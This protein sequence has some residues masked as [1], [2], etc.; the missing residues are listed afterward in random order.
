MEKEALGLDPW[1][2]GYSSPLRPASLLS[3]FSLATA[4]TLSPSPPTPGK[5][6]DPMVGRLTGPLAKTAK[7]A[8]TARAVGHQA[9]SASLWRRAFC[10]V[11]LTPTMFSDSHSCPLSQ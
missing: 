4:E 8:K 11:P 1:G 5:I 7:T 6:V 3:S 9:S 2:G 10:L